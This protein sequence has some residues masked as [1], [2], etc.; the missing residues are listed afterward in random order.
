MAEEGR[1]IAERAEERRRKMLLARYAASEGQ[2]P[3]DWTCFRHGLTMP[4]GEKCPQ[5]QAEW[6]REAARA[7]LHQAGLLTGRAAQQRFETFQAA[8]ATQVQALKA[9][10]D[11]V[12]NFDPGAG[13]ALWLW[14]SG[15]GVGKTHLARAIQFEVLK[16]GRQAA[17]LVWPIFLDEARA[18]SD[19]PGLSSSDALNSLRRVALV[20]LDD[21]GKERS[22]DGWALTEA[23]KLIDFIYREGRAL[24]LT[25]NC[26][27]GELADHVGGAAVSRL[28]EMTDG[29]VD[30]SG[31]DYRTRLRA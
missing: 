31:E 27:P 11:F 8:T 12:E 24:V 16:Q 1:R 29:P 19:Q 22:P 2:P 26:R 18:A 14:S 4:G 9:A 15:Y 7:L 30:V 5:C 10:R 6:R 13:R 20:I 25:T 3:P 23:F 28:W 17:F 21:V